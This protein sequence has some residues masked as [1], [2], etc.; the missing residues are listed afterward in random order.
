MCGITGLIDKKGILDKKNILSDLASAIYHRGPDDYAEYIDDTCAL[1]IRRLAILDLTL[2]LYPFTSEDGKL[3]LVLNGEIYN[4]QILREELKKLGHFF[5]TNCDAEIVLKGYQQWGN[6]VFS[7]L[8]GMFAVALWNKEEKKLTLVRDRVGI[9]P[10][11]YVDSSELF[12]F[13]S[14]AKSFFNLNGSLFSKELDYGNVDIMLGFMF[15][16]K[17]EETLIKN[18]KK[19]PPATITEIQHG[20]ITS[21]KYWQLSDTKE[22]SDISFEEA[23][24]RLDDLLVE[25][26]NI[27]LLSDVPLG[28]LLSGG[29]DSS[30]LAAIM[31]KK[32]LDTKISTFTAKFN[33]KFNESDLA[34]K[35][36][37]E[38]GT[39]HTE[40]IVDTAK[41]N[42]EIEQHVSVFDDLTTFDGGTLT[43]KLLCEQIKKTGVK[44]LLLGEGADEIFGGYSWFG[45]AQQ[46]F[47][48]APAI[49][50]NA[51]YY[52]SISRNISISPLKY[53]N[54]WNETMSNTADVFRDLTKRE[55]E[56]QLPNHL[57]MKVDK[58]SM[59]QSIEAR[60][61]YLDH[62][63]IEFV[64]SLPQ[65]YKLKGSR[66]NTRAANEKYILREVAKKYLSDDIVTRKKRG[67]LLPMHDVLYKNIDKV[68][69]YL[70]SSDSISIKILGKNRVENLF[71][72]APAIIKMQNEY[73]LWRLFILEVWAAH[74][75]L[76]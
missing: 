67:F 41:L 7:K 39:N 33:H 4:F 24:A 27:H 37:L 65:E 49:L 55:V 60:V 35:T 26:V 61:P 11:Y 48:F 32:G 59:S 66:F 47:K 19:L 2:G 34:K 30:L 8:R 38:L 21:I 31:V 57:L 76:K 50:R 25:S 72:G 14:E 73:F 52:Y 62:K 23:V 22:N 3:E 68:K 43:T 46:P 70:L 53:I 16:P 56:I 74:N 42:A 17:S 75:N 12:M 54:F 28:V 44:V 18:V 36:A 5:K 15:L 6:G 20:T 63:L 9:K 71:R 40:F 58:A 51:A 10:I 64:Y 1:A 45:L 13:S 69:Q 29:V